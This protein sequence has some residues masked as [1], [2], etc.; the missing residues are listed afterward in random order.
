MC[1]RV[2]SCTLSA[3]RRGGYVFFIFTALIASSGGTRQVLTKCLIK[4]A[5]VPLSGCFL[6]YAVPG[7]RQKKHTLLSR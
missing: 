4:L 2:P 1:V 5:V 3:S 7:E 6:T